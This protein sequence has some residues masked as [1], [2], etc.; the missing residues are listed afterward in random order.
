MKN[1][2]STKGQQPALCYLFGTGTTE[3]TRKD[4]PEDDTILPQVIATAREPRLQ[5]DPILL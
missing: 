5:K 3:I 4:L 1:N 2:V